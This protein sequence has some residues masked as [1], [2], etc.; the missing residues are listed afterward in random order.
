MYTHSLLRSFLCFSQFAQK[1][2]FLDN[3]IVSIP[4][5]GR[6]SYF[7]PI[8]L[9]MFVIYIEWIIKKIRKVINATIS[10]GAVVKV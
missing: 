1:F 4:D 9:S 5:L 7:N 10:N 6:L 3:L 2:K 8:F